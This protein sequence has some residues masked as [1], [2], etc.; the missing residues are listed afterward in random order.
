[1]TDI[2][3]EISTAAERWRAFR[4]WE[5]GEFMPPGGNPYPDGAAGDD[6]RAF[7]CQ[8]LADWAATTLAE[9]K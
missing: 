8:L 5:A 9:K 3:P 2:D 1:M 4:E 7:D 6:S